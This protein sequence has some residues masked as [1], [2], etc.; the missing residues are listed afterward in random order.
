MTSK[1]EKLCVRCNQVFTT[2]DKRQRYC[3]KECWYSHNSTE[4]LTYTEAKIYLSSI[5]AARGCENCGYCNPIALD[6]D[7]VDRSTK[8]APLARLSRTSVKQSVLQEE[9]AKCM[10]LCANCHVIK[11][12]DNQDWRRPSKRII[13]GFLIAGTDLC[14]LSSGHSGGHRRISSSTNTNS[15]RKERRIWVD[16]LKLAAAC[17]DCG[18]DTDAR[19][20][21]FD[22]VNRGDK[23]LPVASM[24]HYD[25]ER[26]RAEIAKCV[27]RCANCHRLKTKAGGEYRHGF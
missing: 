23:L 3:S 16:A 8:L 12:R 5:K 7:H 14:Q 21:Q 25:E 6:F 13:C 27:I 10:V 22:H 20:L 11:T 17:T 24:L 2:L 9:L 26:L 19:A 4:V 15:R 18:Y 1:Y